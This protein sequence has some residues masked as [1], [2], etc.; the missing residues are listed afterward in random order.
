MAETAAKPKPPRFNHVA[1]SMPADAL[2]AD[3]RAE[4]VAFYNEVFGW[5]EYPMLTEDRRRLVLRVYTNEQFVFLIADDPPMTCPKLDHFGLSM[6]SLDEL[7]AFEDRARA[8]AERDD[9]VEVSERHL[10]DYGMLKLHSVYI[11]YLLPMQVELQHYEYTP[12]T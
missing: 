6:S 11:R 1:M 4:I 10:E 2:A 3:G 12:A 5:E 9:R 7:A 8:F